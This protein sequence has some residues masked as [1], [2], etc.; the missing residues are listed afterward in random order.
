MSQINWIDKSL[1]IVGLATSLI[2]Y[3]LDSTLWDTQAL[4]VVSPTLIA[5]VLIAVHF[6]WSKASRKL[7]EFKELKNYYNEISGTDCIGNTVIRVNNDNGDIVYCRDIEYKVIK[8][9]VT[10]KETSIYSISSSSNQLPNEIAAKSIESNYSNQRL[11]F[12]ITNSTDN[13]IDGK[14]H[15]LVKW[16]Y[17]ISQPLKVKGDYLKFRY[18]INIPKSEEKAFT[19][20]GS[21]ISILSSATYALSR[22]VLIAPS[23]YK[24]EITKYF[25]EDFEKVQ[26]EISENNIPTLDSN[27]EI[28]TWSPSYKKH[29]RYICRYKLVAC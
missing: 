20:E 17:V 19:D 4:L 22:L 26:S 9:G 24:I 11:S 6:L 1:G 8:S 2:I 25:F 5:I 15:K 21:S 18:E 3:F 16:R 29:G 27:R 12:K 28:L 10:L 14:K 7:N 13:V 23:S